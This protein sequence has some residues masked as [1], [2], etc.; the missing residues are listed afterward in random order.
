MNVCIKL[1]REWQAKKNQFSQKHHK[2][3]PHGDATDK[4]RWSPFI[5]IWEASVSNISFETDI[6][7]PTAATQC[8]SLTPDI[9]W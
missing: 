8:G 7:T 3:Q 9:I 5:I 2:W 6:S 4:I 1:T